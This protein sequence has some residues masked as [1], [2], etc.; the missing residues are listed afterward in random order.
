MPTSAINRLVDGTLLLNFFDPIT[1]T[2][3]TEKIYDEL[4]LPDYDRS[5]HKCQLINMKGDGMFGFQPKDSSQIGQFI[6]RG[7]ARKRRAVATNPIEIRSPLI[8]IGIGQAVVF[9]INLKA[10]NRSLS[11]YPQYSKNHLFNTNPSFDYGNFRQLHTI[12]QKTNQTITTFVQ[13]F[14]EPGVHVFY[15]NASP[16]RETIVM[17]PAAGSACPDNVAMDS[18]TVPKLTINQISK[19]KVGGCLA[20]S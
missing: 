16:A 11:N 10:A 19:G 3:V 2:T 9:K 17:V 8:C 1:K 18:A 15:D 7:S 13:R 20:L 5:S 6:S 14:T 4:G 12:I